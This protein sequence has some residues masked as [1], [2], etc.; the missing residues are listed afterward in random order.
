MNL[1]NWKY[2]WPSE[3]KVWCCANKGVGCDAAHAKLTLIDHTSHESQVSH[4]SFDCNAG[5]QKWQTG[6][7]DD[8]KEWCCAHQKV[9]C[10][11]DSHQSFDC[12]AGF[13]K[14]QT[15]WSDDKKEWCCAHY[16]MGCAFDCSA[17]LEVFY[18]A[19]S[20]SKKDWCC[21]NEQKG[22]VPLFDCD[23][24]L[25]SFETSWSHSKKAWCC[26]HKLQGCPKQQELL[27]QSFEDRPT[28]Q[29]PS[30][31]E[32]SSS[33]FLPAHAV[34]ATAVLAAFAVLAAAGRAWGRHS[35]AE[36]SPDSRSAMLGGHE[37]ADEEGAMAT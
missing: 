16:K 10:P 34:P 30:Q 19:W 31:L 29:L 5:F 33:S 17:D 15:G 27:M 35:Q 18:A 20:T 22:C 13:Q 12:N 24:A 9:G 32:D 2:L 4:Q 14:W 25:E 28:D 8:K 6:W 3:K 37:Q 36:V 1:L 7:S 11:I 21:Q 26:K 23:V